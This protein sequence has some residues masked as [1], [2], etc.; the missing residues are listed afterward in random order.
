VTRA[1][2]EQLAAITVGARPALDSTIE[3]SPYDPD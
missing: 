1:R 3:L 2:D